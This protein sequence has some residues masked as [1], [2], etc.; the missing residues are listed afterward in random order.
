ME[1]EILVTKTVNIKKTSYKG[2]SKIY[3]RCLYKW[4]T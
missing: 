4:G 1:A 2:L 3:A